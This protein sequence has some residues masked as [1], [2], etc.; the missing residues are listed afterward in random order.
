MQSNMTTER[1]DRRGPDHLSVGL[2]VPMGLGDSNTLQRSRHR[3][4]RL[5][6]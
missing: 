2:L 4:G 3:V 1:G 6:R 5:R